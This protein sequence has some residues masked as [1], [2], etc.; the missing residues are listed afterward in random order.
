ME[1]EVERVKVQEHRI[2][3]EGKGQIASRIKCNNV[4]FLFLLLT[5][6]HECTSPTLTVVPL[7]VQT[8]LVLESPASG[9]VKRSQFQNNKSLT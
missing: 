6:L 3:G 8:I 4:L 9:N 2:Q 1:I 7:F 5:F